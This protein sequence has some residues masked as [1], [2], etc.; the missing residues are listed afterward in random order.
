MSGL[1][2][3]KIDEDERISSSGAA[4]A[5]VH[6]ARRIPDDVWGSLLQYLSPK[7]SM[8]LSSA[9]S[10]L[11]EAVLHNISSIQLWHTP[12]ALPVARMTS[13]RHISAFRNVDLSAA[14]LQVRDCP[15]L[16]KLEVWC[17]TAA[18]LAAVEHHLPLLAALESVTLKNTVVDA[19]LASVLAS[20]KSLRDVHVAMGLGREADGR[21]D[22]LTDFLSEL[23]ALSCLRCLSGVHLCNAEQ[24]A[25]LCAAVG[26]WAQLEEL[27][28]LSTPTSKLHA[29]FDGVVAA[30]AASCPR[31]RRLCLPYA[32]RFL[33]VLTREV[34]QSIACLTELRD[35]W[36]T[37]ELSAASLAPLRAL[38]KVEKL[39]LD[40]MGKMDAAGGEELAALIGQ[41]PLTKLSLA[42]LRLPVRATAAVLRA[43]ALPAQL[44]QVSIV[45]TCV[46]FADASKALL[47]EALAEAVCNSAVR[48]WKVGIPFPL[49]SLLRAWDGRVPAAAM[50]RLSLRMVDSGDCVGDAYA[51]LLLRCLR[52]CPSLRQV[53]FSNTEGSVDALVA[54]V[55]AEPLGGRLKLVISVDGKTA[56]KY[57]TVR[58]ELQ[59]AGLSLV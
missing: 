50:T 37:G 46:E 31:L 41:L 59:A 38:R 16:R 48:R 27:E 18:M 7:H 26:A 10:W 24:T 55:R 3:A 52:S 39:T 32:S 1:E 30:A 44:T 11:R 17:E 14:L 53:G 21:V 40:R 20:C 51:D 8:A 5:S 47:G 58:N 45:C 4:D 25:A 29:H 34:T 57:N 36:L 54:A 49:I 33:P 42:G 13:L 9:S 35:V 22:C 12:S 19:G 2:E 23:S 43:M 6:A 28:V 15:Q 56:S